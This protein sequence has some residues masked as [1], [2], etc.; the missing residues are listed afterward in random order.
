MVSAIDRITEGL[1]EEQVVGIPD[2]GCFEDFLRKHA[3]VLDKS[4]ESMPY[5]FEGRE[6]LI[7]VARLIDLILGSHTGKCLPDAVVAI[8]GGAQF[9][10][11]IIVLLLMAYLTSKEFRNVGI[12]LPDDDLVEGI[13]DGKL[14]PEVIDLHS[15]YADMIQ[16]AKDTAA[17]GKAVNRKGAVAV[18]D[19]K[20]AAMAM[21]RGMG[22]IPTS[23]S[24]DV[25]M[26]DEKDDIDPKKSKYLSGRTASKELRLR[27]S[28]GTQRFHGMG[29]N[30][31]FTNG[32]QDVLIFRNHKTGA[33]WNLEENWPQICRMQMGAEPSPEDPKLTNEA[34]FKRDGDHVA[35]YSPD[36]LYY[37]A[38]LEDGTPL[39][40]SKP[41]VDRRRADRE[42]LRRF[43][44]RIPQIA[45]AALSLQQAVSRW[46]AAVSDPES[47]EVFRCEVL[48]D[49]SNAAQAIT[50]QIIE[51]AQGVEPFDLSLKAEHPVFA[52]VDTGDRCWFT[53]IEDESPKRQRVVWAERIA[54]DNLL[55]RCIALSKKLKVDCLFVDAGPLRDTARHIVYALNGLD[56]EPIVQDDNPEKAYIRFSSGLVWNGPAGR[57][58]NLKAATVEFTLKPGSG[59][60][61]KLGKTDEGKLYPV[62]QASRDDTI[63]G[64]I[65]DLLTEADGVIEVIDGELRDEPKLLLPRKRP[66]AP[67]AVE[68]LENH[69]LAG[70]K[71]DEDGKF[72]DKCENHYLLG[73]GYGRLAR[74]I[75]TKN[76]SRP[77]HVAAVTSASPSSSR[78]DW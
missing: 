40:R 14:R 46:V 20:R 49:P 71:K 4:G 5:T 13:V 77:S 38:D 68:D 75:G 41:D 37:V 10:K 15:W 12:Y 24:M 28:I 44:I 9:G 3:R 29:Q 56:D 67:A 65:N 55:S 61:H 36:A 54:G 2:V 52:G 73:L 69:I 70:S 42:K 7:F 72:V 62:V 21:I 48:A 78:K 39:D 23:F 43:S 45:C 31:E 76:V 33:A 25:V 17:S 57:W 6:C 51:R 1:D 16:L 34:D 27:I 47:M 59:V 74:T 19:G 53:A 58:E 64:V 66:G 8:C 18:S 63:S 32:T 60:K 50:P 35:E 22:K 11:T 30:K 26:E